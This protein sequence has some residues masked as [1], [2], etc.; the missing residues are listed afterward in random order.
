M[1]A[2]NVTAEVKGTKLTLS[3]D[4]SQ[5]HGDSASGKTTIIGSSGSNLEVAPGVYANVNIYKRK[6]K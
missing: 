6:E 1:A 2:R 4:L 5:E 3:I